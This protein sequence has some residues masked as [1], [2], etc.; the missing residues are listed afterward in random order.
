MKKLILMGALIAS[1]S[2]LKAQYALT[3]DA[4]LMASTAD[5]EV[6][7]YA[8]DVTTESVVGQTLPIPVSNLSGVIYMDVSEIPWDDAPSAAGWCWGHAAVKAGCGTPTQSSMPNLCSSYNMDGVVIGVI[9]YADEDCFEVQSAACGASIG[10]TVV[11]AMGNS[12]R[13]SKGFPAFI[14]IR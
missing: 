13:E 4:S 1:C 8:V 12:G 3:I 2:T 6:I 10:Q 7:A 11:V 9:N 14:Y 5:L